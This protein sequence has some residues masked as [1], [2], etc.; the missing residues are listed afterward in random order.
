MGW[1]FVAMA[2]ILIV[3]WCISSKKEKDAEKNN[4]QTMNLQSEGAAVLNSEEENA[5]TNNSEQII[6][7][8]V[9]TGMNRLASDASGTDSLK[10]DSMFAN[11][12]KKIKSVARIF[13]WVSMVLFAIGGLVMI[14]AGCNNM[15]RG[16][17]TL[18]ISGIVT[19]VAGAF[20]SWLSALVVYGLGTMIENSCVRTEIAVKQAIAQEEANKAE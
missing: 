16:G 3:A 9:S 17:E 1:V 13:C 12:G 20:I 11:P 8:K 5:S 18:I 19:A 15:H 6:P 2:A 4:S 7:E 14:I 10:A